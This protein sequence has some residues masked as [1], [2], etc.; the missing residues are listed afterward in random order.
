[1]TRMAPQPIRMSEQ[2]DRGGAAGT[3]RE[4]Q[5][6]WQVSKA[7]LPDRCTIQ[8]RTLAADT[9]GSQVETW[10]STYP[11]VACRLMGATA[12]FGGERIFAARLINQADYLLVVAYE[13]SLSVT[14]RI[15]NVTGPDG[16]IRDAGPFE[17]LAVGKALSERAATQAMLR[18]VT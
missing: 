1:M 10:T 2:L 9:F 7:A 18:R 3:P 5:D 13:Q 16:A 4:R 12:G 11:A 8:T 6:S 17:I 15:A 14:D